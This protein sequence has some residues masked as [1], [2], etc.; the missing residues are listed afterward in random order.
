MPQRFPSQRPIAENRCAAFGNVRPALPSRL[1]V[2]DAIAKTFAE[3]T[4]QQDMTA[5]FAVKRR[6]PLSA[7]TRSTEC[8]SG[9]LEHGDQFDPAS[10]LDRPGGHSDC[11]GPLQK[12]LKTAK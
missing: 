3:L 10:M 1:K 12:I 4:S 9:G 7:L 2:I 8:G 11:K 5:S 6:P